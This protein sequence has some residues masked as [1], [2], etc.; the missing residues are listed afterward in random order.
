[1]APAPRSLRAATIRNNVAADARALA[2]D[3]QST[4]DLR[5]SL[6]LREH[7]H[8]LPGVDNRG[9]P[10]NV[11]L[12]GWQEN[13]GDRSYIV[14][15][16]PTHFIEINHRGNFLDPIRSDLRSDQIGSKK[17]PDPLYFLQ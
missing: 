16:H 2:Q 3:A 6:D 7:S 1:M 14:T 5:L 11:H 4:P 10:R 15:H 12:V 8:A 9:L 13:N 17:S